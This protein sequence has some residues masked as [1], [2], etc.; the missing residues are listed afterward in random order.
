MKLALTVFV[1]AAATVSAQELRLPAAFAKLAEK[2]EE[3]VDIRLDDNLL[4]LAGMSKGK[5]A[6]GSLDIKNVGKLTGGFIRSYEFK[7]EGAY[8]QADVDQFVSQ[9]NVGGWACLVSVHSKKD[10]ETSK[11][12]MHHRGDEVDGMAIVN[13]EP[14]ELTI[15]NLTGSITQEELNKLQGEFHI[16]DVQLRMEPKAA[17]Q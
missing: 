4:K 14:K 3:V 2:A 11:I 13:A 7:T 12:C 8:S 17:K 15:V 5:A 10:R 1:L 9:M 16:P 6:H